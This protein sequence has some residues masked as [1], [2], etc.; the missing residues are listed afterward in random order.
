MHNQLRWK[1]DGWID[2]PPQLET[3]ARSAL[4]RSIGMRN[5]QT[6]YWPYSIY[7]SDP[8]MQRVIM[9]RSDGFSTRF[10]PESLDGVRRPVRIEQMVDK[11]ALERS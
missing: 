4:P 5:F 8:A 3:E 1:R 2:V 9:S 11:A 10:Q 6:A 7:E